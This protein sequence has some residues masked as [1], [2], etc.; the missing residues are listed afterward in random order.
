MNDRGR[1]KFWNGALLVGAGALIGLMLLTPALA[2]H[3]RLSVWQRVRPHADSRY[4][5]NS[6]VRVSATHEVAAA[7]TDTVSIDCPA[8][9][10]AIGGGVDVDQP[11]TG[12]SVVANGPTVQSGGM[13]S[14]T[15]GVH[16]PA[17][18]WKVSI[19]NDDVTTA[20]EFVVGVICSA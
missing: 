4:L 6:T 10:Q 8:G 13:L 16:P 5:Q 3:R 9:K 18:G 19:V 20:H 7:A 15:A 17:S 11:A 14:T 12:L 1:V 2:A